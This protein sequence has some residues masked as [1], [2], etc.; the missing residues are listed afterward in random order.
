MFLLY[1]L[2]SCLLVILQGYLAYHDGFL[3]QKQL[4]NRRIHGYSFFQHGGMWADFFILSWLLAFILTGYPELLQKVFT[5]LSL[6]LLGG[7]IAVT[8]CLDRFWAYGARQ[9]PEPHTR[10][11]RTTP[12]GFVHDFHTVIAIWIVV[13]FYFAAGPSSTNG[14]IYDDEALKFMLYLKVVSFSLI[15]IFGLGT[16]K[17]TGEWPW[18]KTGGVISVLLMVIVIIVTLLKYPTIL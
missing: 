18:D 7:A 14:K 3:T 11:G 13:M 10:K 17:L 4:I 5:N 6:S 9:K 1:T 8:Y 16:T 12:A 15:A 2:I